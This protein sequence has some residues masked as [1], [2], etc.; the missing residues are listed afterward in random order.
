MDV[1][2]DAVADVLAY[3]T[4]DFDLELTSAVPIDGGVDRTARSFRGYAADAADA[5][6]RG[7]AIK[8][9]SGGSVAGLVL[10]DALAAG[11][12]DGV[13][14]PLRTRGGQLYAEREGRRLSVAPWVGE[15]RGIDGGLDAE[16]WRAFGRLLAATHALK[17]GTA[18]MS[19]LPRADHH[20]DVRETR[21][22]DTLLRAAGRGPRDAIAAEVQRLWFAHADLIAAVT[23]RV[24]ESAPS[25]TPDTVCHT[26]PH[27]GNVLASPGRV[28]LIDWDDAAYSTP[29]HDLMFVLGGAY[30]GEHIG[31]RERAWFFEG[32]GAASI[33]PI[34]LAY[35][36]GSRGLV[37]A[38]FLAAEAYGAGAGEIADDEG[39]RATALRM[40]AEQFGARGM[41]ARSLS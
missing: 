21:K 23:A 17:P 28:W 18:L 35:W 34:R 36:R 12:V 6:S 3:L 2:R 20:G 4:E 14:A 31:D 29:E 15:R 30:G 9:S 10:P 27:L 16:Q 22:T 5:S 25:V 41:L 24:E 1:P 32:Y 13:A 33:D 19:V 7:Y 11:A 26:D 8:W 40:L 39:W 37:D 38:A